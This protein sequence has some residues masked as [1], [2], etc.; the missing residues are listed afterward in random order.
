MTDNQAL[1][2]ASRAL[3]VIEQFEAVLN[4]LESFINTL[5]QIYYDEGQPLLARLR[6]LY[7]AV[8]VNEGS[9]ESV[10]MLQRQGGKSTIERLRLESEVVR[11]SEEKGLSNSEIA[12]R[13]EALSEEM[14]RRFLKK[15]REA[16]PSERARVRRSSIFDTYDQLE[17]VAALI[18][19][20]LARYEG[21]DGNIH[22]KYVKEL[23]ELIRESHE[24]MDRASERQK[25]DEIALEV[26]DI[27]AEFDEEKAVKLA[28]RL[29]QRG[30][31]NR[32]AAAAPKELPKEQVEQSEH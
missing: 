5:P 20:Q 28:K 19:R 11:L 4:D 9:L 31:G 29:E 3:A 8:D 18:Y 17:K 32:L 6:S 13:F 12:E 10:Q 30:L 16:K 15:Y 2:Q 7:E 1:Q 25:L 26:R 14:I 23:R 21:Q 24:W 27:V 22:V